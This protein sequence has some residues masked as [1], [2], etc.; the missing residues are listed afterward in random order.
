M[1]EIV[2]R[3]TPVTVIIG[4]DSQRCLGQRV[5]NFLPR[6]CGNYEIIDTKD[7]PMPGFDEA[8][9]GRLQNAIFHRVINRMDMHLEQIS[10]HPMEI[11]RY[12]HRLDY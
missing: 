6:I 8:F 10:C 12:Y 1:L 5:R 4:E 2:E 11:R 7:Y 3:D 9:R